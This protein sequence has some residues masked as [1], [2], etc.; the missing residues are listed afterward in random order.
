MP[1]RF[2]LRRTA[3]AVLSLTV[4]PNLQVPIEEPLP[5]GDARLEGPLGATWTP[6][7]VRVTASRVRLNALGAK[8]HANWVLFRLPFDSTQHGRIRRVHFEAS[9]TTPT[10]VGALRIGSVCMLVPSSGG[11]A[12]WTGYT[13]GGIGPSHPL[14]WHFAPPTDD[15]TILGINVPTRVANYAS[16]GWDDGTLHELARWRLDVWW[17]ER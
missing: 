16:C 2:W 6:K 4:P 11:V 15:P 5:R 10:D 3:L 12:Q 7:H 8:T 14:R 9:A 1:H 17:E 13:V